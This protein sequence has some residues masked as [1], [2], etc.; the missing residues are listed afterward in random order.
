MEGMKRFGM[1]GLWG[2]Y[3][4]SLFFWKLGIGGTQIVLEED[5][6]GFR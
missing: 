1:G 3:F 6:G 2:V 5:F 4:S